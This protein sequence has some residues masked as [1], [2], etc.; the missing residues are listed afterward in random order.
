VVRFLSAEW[1]EQAGTAVGASAAVT[2]AVAGATP[3]VLQQHVT[4]TPGG[5]VGYWTRLGDGGA[6]I[7]AGTAPDAAVTITSDYGLASELHRGEISPPKA[8][9]SGRA[10][11]SGDMVELMRRQKALAALDGALRTIPTE[12]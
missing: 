11:V 4:G 6:A 7:G 5:D 3:F 8:M 9:M 10:R 12:Y 2:A 1:I